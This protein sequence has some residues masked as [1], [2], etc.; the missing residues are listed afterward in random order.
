MKAQTPSVHVVA[1]LIRRGTDV[2]LVKQQGPEDPAPS[3]S[4][5]GGVVEAGELLPE[6]LAREVVEECGL[7]I[8]DPGRILYAAQQQFPP[9][10]WREV[11]DVVV[12]VFEVGDWSGKLFCDDP[13][14]LAAAACFLSPTEAIALLETAPLRMMR[15]PVAAYLRGEANP[16]AM[17]FYRRL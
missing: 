15:E 3:W 2:L 4:L 13:D 14:G 10:A 1:A 12:F 7:T 6:S 9:G 5:P 16:A 17:W 11:E 8:L